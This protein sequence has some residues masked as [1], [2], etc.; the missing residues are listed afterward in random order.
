MN[1]TIFS[2]GRS[3]PHI[4][5]LNI[6]SAVCQMVQSGKSSPRH[7][8][9]IVVPVCPVWYIIS[10]DIHTSAFSVMANMSIPALSV[11]SE[12]WEQTF[13]NFLKKGGKLC[14]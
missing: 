1:A 11:C 12:L 14:M 2:S 8:K 7:Q 13:I 9:S 4:L 3:T 10:L 6:K 5:I